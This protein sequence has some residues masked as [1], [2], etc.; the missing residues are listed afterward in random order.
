[1]LA[2]IVTSAPAITPVSAVELATQ[3]HLVTQGPAFSE[4]TAKLELI[5]G[6]ATTAIENMLGRALITQTRTAYAPGIQR[7]YFLPGPPLI[8]L[9]SFTL[10][11]LDG[12]SLAQSTSGWL[13]DTVEG[14]IYT[15]S[16][17][18]FPTDS[19]RELN[20]VEISYKCG[21]GLTA[22]SVPAPIRQA[23]LMLGATLWRSREHEY[24]AVQ[25]PR[26]MDTFRA[27]LSDYRKL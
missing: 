25:E 3:C 20:P 21:Y 24:E 13:L 2:S 11:T 18:T 8:S 12:Q 7:F 15:K 23:I 14:L 22:A 5:C 9:E 1:M 4:I 17:T 6:V 16:A 19:L 27:F 10:K 26:V